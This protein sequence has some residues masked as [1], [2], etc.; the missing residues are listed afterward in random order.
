MDGGK[1]GYVL[2][3]MRTKKNNPPTYGVSDGPN[4]V[5]FQVK[6]SLMSALLDIPAEMNSKGVSLRAIKS[7]RRRSDA[8]DVAIMISLVQIGSKTF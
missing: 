5:A 7:V 4:R 6:T 3:K 8:E 2:G 1:L